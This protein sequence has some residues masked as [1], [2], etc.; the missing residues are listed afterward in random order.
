MHV[1][2]MCFC[3]FR[4]VPVRSWNYTFHCVLW[5]KVWKHWSALVLLNFQP[6]DTDASLFLPRLQWDEY[7]N[8]EE[9]FISFCS[10]LT[11]PVF[12]VLISGF[13]P[14]KDVDQFGCC[15]TCMMRHIYFELFTVKKHYLG[16]FLYM[17]FTAWWREWIVSG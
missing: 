13:V 11:L 4:F 5:W 16:I 17:R 8:W 7:W 1:K 9:A 15:W 10:N 14:L 2:I 3:W 6:L 12:K